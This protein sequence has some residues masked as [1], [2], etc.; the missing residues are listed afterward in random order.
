MF[1]W[2]DLES[3]PKDTWVL[4]GYNQQGDEM[5][6]GLMV[7]VGV[8]CSSGKIWTMNAYDNEKALPSKWMPL[9]DGP[10]DGEDE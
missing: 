2:R 9:P 1:D 8:V 4:L 7:G 3:A 10:K 5:P 6:P